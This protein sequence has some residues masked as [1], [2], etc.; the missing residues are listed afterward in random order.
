MVRNEEKGIFLLL[1][2][3][4]RGT[5]L[6]KKRLWFASQEKGSIN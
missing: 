2:R 1:K 4:E 6:S 3:I 5:C